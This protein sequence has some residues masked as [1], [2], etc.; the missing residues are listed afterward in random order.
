MA[1]SN[2][3]VIHINTHTLRNN[4]K[5]GANDAPIIVRKYSRSSMQPIYCHGVDLKVNDTK[6]GRLVYQPDKPLDCGA[7][8]WLEI[9][10]D[11]VD[12]V[13]VIEE[14]REDENICRKASGA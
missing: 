13:P 8:I 2:N 7:R 11:I 3:K 12:I 14:V 4:T 5:T 6:I 9:D 10:G 1:K